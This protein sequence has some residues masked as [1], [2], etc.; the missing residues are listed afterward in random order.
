MRRPGEAWRRR[1]IIKPHKSRDTFKLNLFCFTLA[2]PSYSHEIVLLLASCHFL[3]PSHPFDTKQ[4]SLVPSD[5]FAFNRNHS[6]SSK[7]RPSKFQRF[8]QGVDDLVYDCSRTP[9]RHLKSLWRQN[10]RIPFGWVLTLHFLESVCVR[11]TIGEFDRARES[12][13]WRA[14]IIRNLFK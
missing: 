5:S 14:N 7:D 11:L 9:T 4:F 3:I 6:Y 2:F 8:Q 13:G 12:T 10:F 1:E